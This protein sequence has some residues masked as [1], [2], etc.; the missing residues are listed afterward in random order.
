MNKSIIEF[1]DKLSPRELLENYFDAKTRAKD[2][3]STLPGEL[4]EDCIARITEA[5]D[6]LAVYGA[7]NK[8]VTRDQ[9]LEAKEKFK[10]SG[11]KF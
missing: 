10:K 7:D 11:F 3:I 4:V 6:K 1:M 2:S 8:I 9:Y 5:I